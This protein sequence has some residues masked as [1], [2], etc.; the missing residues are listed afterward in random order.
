MPKYINYRY[1]FPPRPKNAVSPDDLNF[2]DNGTLICQPKLNGSNCLIFT[3][4]QKIIVMNRHNQR[5]TNFQL[6]DA[7]VKNF[8]RGNGGWMVI[9][10]E[11]MNKS[12]SDETGQAFNHKF[13]IFDILCYDGDYL[14]G[15][16]FEERVNLLDTLYDQVDSEKDYLYSISTNVYRVKSYRDGFKEFFDKYTPIDVIEGVVMKRCNAKLEVGS[17]ELNNSKSQIKCRKS[18][19]NYK[20]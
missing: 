20:Y 5:L 19:K 8:Y 4:G 13:V 18:T 7:E 16:T 17:S 11:Y 10:G 1:I 15:K 2:W 3:N 14:V 6:S 9:N 12:K